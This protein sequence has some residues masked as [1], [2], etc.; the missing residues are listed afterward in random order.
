M[1][2]LYAHLTHVTVP[3]WYL[4]PARQ[5]VYAHLHA[6]TQ[7]TQCAALNCLQ[8][9]IRTSKS[10]VTSM[11]QVE[12]ETAQTSSAA[13]QS[14]T[15]DMVEQQHAADQNSSSHDSTVPKP[16]Q[17]MLDRRTGVEPATASPD[18]G[19]GHMSDVGHVTCPVHAAKDL[20]LC[21]KLDG[22]HLPGLTDNR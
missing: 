10:V 9:M 19:V 8:Q 11:L 21:V 14:L 5:A 12:G 17:P 18:E 13:A 6:L 4:L 15:H 7:V 3:D 2:M 22:L 16:T 1:Q 20:G